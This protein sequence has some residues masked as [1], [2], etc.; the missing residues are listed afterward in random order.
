MHSAAL[1]RGQLQLQTDG[2]PQS[3]CLR[4]SRSPC[5]RRVRQIYGRGPPK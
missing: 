5:T 3:G 1:V 4:A 2:L